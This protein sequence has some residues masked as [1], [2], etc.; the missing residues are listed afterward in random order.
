MAAPAWHVAGPAVSCYGDWCPCAH[1]HKPLAAHGNLVI[2]TVRTTETV[3]PGTMVFGSAATVSPGPAVPDTSAG[4]PHE[5]EGLLAPVARGF[6]PGSPGATG[7]DRL[8]PREP[9]A[10]PLDHRPRRPARMAGGAVRERAARIRRQH[11]APAQGDHRLPRC[12]PRPG[13]RLSQDP[14]ARHLDRRQPV[15][16]RGHPLRR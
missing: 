15:G 1:S 6:A 7:P 8:L 14:V 2:K 3:P 12:R 13:D 10:L 4:P 11:R 5:L 9:G 16:Q